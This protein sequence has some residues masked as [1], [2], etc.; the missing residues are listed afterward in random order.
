MNEK[1]LFLK[2]LKE[3]E[4]LEKGTA[5]DSIRT[6]ARIW[7]MLAKISPIIFIIIAGILWFTGILD[8]KTALYIG[9]VLFVF[10]AVTWWFWTVHTIGKIAIM[11]NKADTGVKDALGDLKEIREILKDIRN[12]R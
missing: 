7:D 10:V 9:G 1:I 2:K 5:A 3:T 4:G 11:L 6:Q 8:L 12:N